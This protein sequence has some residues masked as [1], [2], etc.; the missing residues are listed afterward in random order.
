MV[1]NGMSNTDKPIVVNGKKKS[2]S[3][4]A[5]PWLVI[6]ENELSTRRLREVGVL[7]CHVAL[8]RDTAWE[9][10]GIYIILQ[11]ILVTQ[12]Q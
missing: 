4:T 8:S 11:T 10:I 12:L 6:A 9:R 3:A 2:N 7:L 1:P 5:P